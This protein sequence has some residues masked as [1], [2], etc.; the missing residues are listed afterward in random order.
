MAAK[1]SKALRNYINASGALK[2]ALQ[3]GKLLVYSGPQPATADAAPTGTLLVTI[4]ENSA[5]HTSEIQ[6][7]GRVTLSGTLGGSLDSITVGGFEVLGVVVP[8]ATSLANV[9]ALAAAIINANPLNQLVKAT[10]SGAAITLTMRRG[11]GAGANGMVVDSTCTTMTG[12]DVNIGTTTAGVSSANGLK[13]GESAAGI[14]QMLSTQTRTGVAVAD[15]VAGWARFVGPVADSG[16]A[17]STES[18]IRLDLAIAVS[19]ANLNMAAGTTIQNGATETMPD[20]IF[21]L[22]TL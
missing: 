15:G 16:I 12:T 3:G 8:Y 14:M 21:T 20:T 19:G 22:P 7:Q 2:D 9:A 18:Q 10:V 5:A 17:D 13:F 4:T 11:W 6:A 1:F